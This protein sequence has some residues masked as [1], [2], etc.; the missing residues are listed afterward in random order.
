[1][2]VDNDG[3]VDRTEFCRGIDELKKRNSDS[4]LSFDAETLFD[5]I[6]VDG[7]GTIELSEFQ[8]AFQACDVPYHVAVMMTLDE[9][10]SGTIDR[11]EFRDGVRLLNARLEEE[12]K[13]PAETDEEV[14]RL[15]DELDESGDGELDIVEFEKF[16]RD[17]YPH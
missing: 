10:K 4:A 17:Y 13:I 3:E 8:H 1:M 11:Q 9:D 16:I 6:D 5:S 12:E 15:F 14:N 2:D 7:S